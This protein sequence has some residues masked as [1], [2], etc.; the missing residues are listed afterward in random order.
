MCSLMLILSRLIAPSG[1]REAVALAP[2]KTGWWPLAKPVGA[3]MI[4][5]VFAIYA[6]L[7]SL[8]T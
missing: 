2:A 3:G 6:F 5:L 4:V 1:S 7:H 8:G